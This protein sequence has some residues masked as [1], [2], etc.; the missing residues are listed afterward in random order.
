MNEII[1]C[2]Y[3]EIVLKGANRK[4]FENLLHREMR[5]RMRLYGDCEVTHAQSTITV[6]PLSSDFDIEGAFAEAKKVFGLVGVSRALKVE[7]SMEAVTE[8]LR[9]RAPEMLAGAKTFKVE[10]KRSDKAFPLNSP[11]ICDACGGVILSLMPHIKVDVR[12]PDVVVRVE[13]RDTAAFIHA[14]QEKG[15]GGMPVGSNGRALLM[16]SGGIDSPV[17]GYMIA[18][19]GVKIEALHFESF[20]YTSVRA[21]EKVEALAAKLTAYC[22]DIDLHVISVTKIQEALNEHCE[23][24]Y[25]TLLL[26]RFM[27]RLA[28]LTAQRNHCMAHITGES[29][30]QVASQTMEALGVTNI[31]AD[32]PV[33][34]PCVGMDKE[35][36]IAISRKIDTFD[37]SIEPFEDCCTVF[38]PRHPRTKPELWKVERE[39]AKVD[40]DALVEEAF[41][42]LYTIPVKRSR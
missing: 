10:A 23:E 7:K 31:V 33:L 19:R 4:Y 15:A 21:R 36:I 2:K 34:R 29:L 41:A 13:I 32:R 8:G 1:L 26:R 3:G 24:D 5:S 42:T 30:G 35:E 37:I 17:A 18:K 22:G 25:F 27:M 16:L 39:E 11:Q 14:G 12:N 28:N 9:A 40:V 38:T 20:P 6:D